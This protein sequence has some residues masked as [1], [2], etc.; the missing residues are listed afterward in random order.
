[1]LLLPEGLVFRRLLLVMFLNGLLALAGVH[2]LQALAELLIFLVL[3]LHMLPVFLPLLLPVAVTAAASATRTLSR[4]RRQGGDHRQT[5][6]PTNHAFPF[7]IYRS[8]HHSAGVPARQAD[9]GRVDRFILGLPKISEKGLF[10]A[11]W[12]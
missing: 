12:R 10:S 7:H 11:R 9:N 6:D 3:L 4:D 8:L 5:Y 2:A 1:M